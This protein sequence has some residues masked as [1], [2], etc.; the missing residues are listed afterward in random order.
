M[1]KE[2]IGLNLILTSSMIMDNLTKHILYGLQTFNLKMGLTLK[3]FTI[4]QDLSGY[5]IL[6]GSTH[7]PRPFLTDT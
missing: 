5:Y 1:N 3:N 7:T 2:I 4:V 6:Y